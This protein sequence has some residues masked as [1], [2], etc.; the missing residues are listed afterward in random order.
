MKLI[1]DL[2][3]LFRANAEYLL[4]FIKRGK[5][6]FFLQI[7][8]WG[9]SVPINV[10]SVYAPKA[11]VEKTFEQHNLFSG[12]LWICLLIICRLFNFLSNQYLTVYRNHLYSLSKIESK[13]R[14]YAKLKELYLSFFD[15]PERLNRFNRAFSYN[16]SGGAVFIDSII[17]F[18][19]CIVSL[20][21]MTIISTSFE[22]WLWIVVVLLVFQQYVG[23]RKIKKRNFEFTKE[24]T[25]RDREQNYFAS[26]P[27]QPVCLSELLINNGF[28]FF[29]RKYKRIYNE[30]VSFQKKHS[31]SVG[32]MTF[33]NML[34]N[35]LFSLG[36][37]LIIGIKLIEGSATIGDYTLFFS[38]II[39]ISANLKTLFYSFNVFYQQA[40]EAQEYLDFIRMPDCQRIHLNSKLTISMIKSIE[41]KDVS[42]K[43]EGVNHPTIKHLNVS[44]R[45]GDRIA[46]VGNNGAGKTTFVKLLLSLYPPEEGNIEIN[47]KPIQD[48]DAD[49]YW[50][51]I[52]V[53]L[54]NHQEFA[55]T[56]IENILLSDDVD[57][58]IDLANEVI[59]K[60]GLKEKIDSLKNGVFSPFTHL[61]SPNGVEFSGGERQRLAIARALAKS[62]DLYVFDE[63]SSALDPMA[64]DELLKCMNMIE[65][66][67]IVIYISHRLSNIHFC[68][69]ILFFQDGQIIADGT[70]QELMDSCD[71]YRNA[72]HT[73]SKK[74]HV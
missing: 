56:L 49:A 42:F 24:K 22:W 53:V 60:V 19:T 30:N 47:G 1:K 12:I 26:V 16:D 44:F 41:F 25:I 71:E 62:S 9:I 66:D 54:Q 32:L 72:Y 6:Y 27:T 34:P 50:E 5:L 21:T 20:F 35:E 55:L 57:S 36:C 15:N 43:Y 69:R 2:R 51:R 61:F 65:K 23:D 28:D 63:P 74:Y 52:S 11:F 18:F 45:S 13:E 37:Y 67:R 68:N 3:I 4:S 29:F 48:Y 59:S 64:E 46:I 33:L 10:V 39:N 70:H 17:S 8:F 7:L 38:L 40:L 73:Q 58:K 14:A 31:L